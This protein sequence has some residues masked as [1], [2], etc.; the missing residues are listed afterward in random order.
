MGIFSS[1]AVIFTLRSHIN[2][3]K[4]ANEVIYFALNI[5]DKVC[6]SLVTILT[7]LTLL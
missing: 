4:L 6:L 5:P 2:S 1:S 7:I 3:E